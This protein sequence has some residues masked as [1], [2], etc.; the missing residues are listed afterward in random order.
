MQPTASIAW[1]YYLIP[2][3][4]SSESEAGAS[5]DEVGNILTGDEEKGTNNEASTLTKLQ[6]NPSQMATSL[7]DPATDHEAEDESEGMATH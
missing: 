7:V 1:E 6:E 4:D 3:I 5:S 2:P